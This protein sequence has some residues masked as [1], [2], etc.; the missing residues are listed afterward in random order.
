MQ[1]EHYA[2]HGVR[3]SCRVGQP[4]ACWKLSHCHCSHICPCLPGCPPPPAPL[5]WTPKL[6]KALKVVGLINIQYAV[7]DNTV[8]GRAG[9][10]TQK[11]AQQLWALTQA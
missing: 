10:Q 1:A 6:A 5:Q 7:Q 11:G 4:A 3:H 9:R 2:L 8:S